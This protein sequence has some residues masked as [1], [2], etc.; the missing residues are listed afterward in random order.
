MLWDRMAGVRGR[1]FLAGVCA[2]ALFASGVLTVGRELNSNCEYR[3]YA[4][5][6]IAAAEYLRQTAP[7]D[8]L[9]S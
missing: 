4:D 3:L 6:E 9:A 7:A 2:V 5:D 1:A 8:A